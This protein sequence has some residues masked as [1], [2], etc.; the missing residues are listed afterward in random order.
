VGETRSMW[1]P[2][3]A[4]GFS[5]VGESRQ[6]IDRTGP[7]VGAAARARPATWGTIVGRPVRFGPITVSHF[8]FPFYFI[9]SFPFS[10]LF[11][12]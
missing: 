9:F 1:G 3:S 4:S 2:V 10:F 12:F 7:H 11:N 8:S 5:M 6:A